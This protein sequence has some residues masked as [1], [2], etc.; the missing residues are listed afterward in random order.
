MCYLARDHRLKKWFCTV[1]P[2]P[3]FLTVGQGGAGWA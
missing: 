1:I 3:Y 2:H